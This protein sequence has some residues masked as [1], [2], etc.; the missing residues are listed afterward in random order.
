MKTLLRGIVSSGWKGFPDDPETLQYT[1][2]TEGADGLLYVAIRDN[3]VAL[4]EDMTSPYNGLATVEEKNAA[5]PV[6]EDE[7]YN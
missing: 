1:T 4:L 6:V 7:I 2:A 3:D 5:V